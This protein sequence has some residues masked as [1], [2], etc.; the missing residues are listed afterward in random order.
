MSEKL[1]FEQNA[2]G[3]LAIMTNLAQGSQDM[4]IEMWKHME[5][6]KTPSIEGILQ[7]KNRKNES[8]FQLCASYDQNQLLLEMCNSQNLS[9]ECIMKALVE[10]NPDGQ[11]TL[12][13]C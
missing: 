12:N 8:I 11:T 13:M 1:L 2:A 7:L 3:N 4:A 5:I 6:L 9:K 10:Q